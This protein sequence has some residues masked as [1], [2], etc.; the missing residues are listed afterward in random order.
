MPSFMGVS[1]VD[2][3]ATAAPGLNRDIP[4]RLARRQAALFAKPSI[5]AYWLLWAPA[6]FHPMNS[7]PLRAGLVGF[8]FAGQTFHAPV[9]SAVPG[10]QLG[11]VASSQP[12]KVQAEWPGVVVVVGV[13]GRM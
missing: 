10:L 8:G 2:A 6:P 13:A 11:A 1:L 7:R 9:L 5:I 3:R 12:H 4:V